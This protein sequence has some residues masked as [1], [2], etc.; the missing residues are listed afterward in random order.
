MVK[1]PLIVLR[2]HGVAS[3]LGLPNE[4]SECSVHL[5]WAGGGGTELESGPVYAPIS[6][7]V[8][9][10]IGGENRFSN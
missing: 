3:L 9:K 5:A 8:R 4:M 6:N 1:A 7:K 10:D 2:A